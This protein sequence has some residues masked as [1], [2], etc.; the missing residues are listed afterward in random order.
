MDSRRLSKD[1]LHSFFSFQVAAVRRV[2]RLKNNAAKRATAQT[3]KVLQGMAQNDDWKED[4]D[5]QLDSILSNASITS[6]MRNIVETRLTNMEQRNQ[7]IV[8]FIK[9]EQSFA[10]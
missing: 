2:W 10:V 1:L 5:Q 8:N 3:K 6:S 4:V 9:K 7:Q